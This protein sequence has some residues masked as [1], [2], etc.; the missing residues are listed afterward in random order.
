MLIAT[1]YQPYDIKV[2]CIEKMLSIKFETNIF[3]FSKTPEL[4]TIDIKFNETLFTITPN[5]KWRKIEKFV[6]SN[7]KNE[8]PSR[9]TGE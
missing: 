6:I 1:I 3:I 4:N 8:E 2:K 7:L 5:T 9:D